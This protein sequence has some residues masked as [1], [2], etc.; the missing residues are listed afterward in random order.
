MNGQFRIRPQDRS[1]QVL[2]RWLIPGLLGCMLAVPG[3]SRSFW[4]QQADKDTYHAMH[5]IELDPRW[6]NPRKNLMPDPRSRFFD[7][8]DPD[9]TPLTPDDPA[10]AELMKNPGGI[11]GYK[12]WHELGRS[13]AIE[14]PGWLSQFQFTPEMIDEETGEYTCQLP[15]IPDLKILDAIEL[16]YLHSREYQFE[17]EQ[18]YLAALALTFERFRFQVRFLGIGGGEPG[19]S[20]TYANVPGFQD[21]LNKNTSIGVSQLLPTGGQWAV[22]LANNTLWIFSGPNAGT[23]SASLLSYRL[24][25]P[26]LLGAGRKIALEDLTQAERDLL[27]AVRS[28]ARYR[29]ILFVQTVAGGQTGGYLGLLTQI[30]GIRNQQY[31]IRQLERQVREQRANAAI[32]PGTTETLLDRLPP[33][34]QFPPD[35]QAKLRYDPDRRILIWSGSMT[36]EQATLL[37]GL[38]DDLSWQVSTRE[39]IQLLRNDVVPLDVAQLESRLARSFIQLRSSEQNFQDR[40]DAYKIQLGLPPDI[41]VSIDDS[42]LDQFVLID[43]LLEDLQAETETF[44]ERTGLLNI[45]EPDL[46]LARQVL[47]EARQV[48]QNIM[49]GGVE[50]VERDAAR[51]RENLPK[52]LQQIKSE[53]SRQLIYE[54]VERDQEQLANIKTELQV[55]GKQLEVI[56]Q[57]LRQAD[58][59]EESLRAAIPELQSLRE[60]MLLRVQGL[61]V[62]QVGMRSELINVN[63]YPLTLDD[64]IGLA[65]ENR[66]DLMNARADIVDAR[67][68]EEVAANRL[69]AVLDV[70]VEGDIR[71]PPG[72]SHPFNFSGTS[73]SHRVG[74]QFTAPLDQVAERN[75]YRVSQINYQRARRNYML[76]ED[77]VKL[78]IRTAWRNLQILEENLETARQAL[79]I[80]VIQ[81]DQ[82]VEESNDPNR[83]SQGGVRG[84]NLVDALNGILDAQDQLVSIWASYERARLEMYRDMDVMEID[85]QGVWVDDYYQSLYQ[86]RFESLETLPDPVSL[87]PEP[88]AVDFDVLLLPPGPAGMKHEHHTTTRS[89]AQRSGQPADFPV[90]NQSGNP[91]P[92]NELPLPAPAVRRE[93]EKT[94]FRMDPLGW[95]PGDPPARLLD[96][97]PVFR[98]DQHRQQRGS[99]TPDPADSRP[100]GGAG[101]AQP[102]LVRPDHEDGPSLDRLP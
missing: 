47:L 71:N 28:L 57:Y 59:N 33:G 82:A 85:P 68:Q 48:Y 79:R 63:R 81:Y 43:P 7:P 5:Q 11:P 75:S 92:G 29:K 26:L 91:N 31:N 94:A 61:Q 67:R 55:L 18:A 101:I 44:V 41:V 6:V 90:G 19:T 1:R 93:P 9:K 24:V 98:T 49:K 12:S 30:Q 20:L 32:P 37:S 52:R 8:H 58:T 13:F 86:D 14:N 34:L 51:V 76:L 97:G 10:A 65:L 38:S 77:Q 80:N 27:Y 15:T 95:Q 53:Q 78:N 40:L 39:L 84:R 2:R 35:L 62:V 96:D 25:Q 64:S 36:P 70:I 100:A 46:E 83:S 88:T 42:G 17:L 74:L 4:R 22:E 56:S 73:S 21:S 54:T 50:L 60:E 16:T 89:E 99:G 87:P 102:A 72:S 3:C 23:N 45:D 66:L 69:K